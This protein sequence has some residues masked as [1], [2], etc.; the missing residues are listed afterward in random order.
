MRKCQKGLGKAWG[1]R[2]N[3]PGKMKEQTA[4]F[5]NPRVWEFIQRAMK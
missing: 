1:D 4:G 5:V 3:W 2:E